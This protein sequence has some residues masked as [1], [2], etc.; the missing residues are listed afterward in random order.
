MMNDNSG[1]EKD[2]N[3][4]LE[5]FETARETNKTIYLDSEDYCDI[6][7]FYLRENAIENGHDAINRGLKIHPNHTVLLSIQVS[8]YIAEDKLTEAR[9]VLESIPNRNNIYAR[10]AEGELLTH[11]GEKEVA[12]TILKSIKMEDL[13]GDFSLMV[14]ITFLFSQ[15]EMPDEALEWIHANILNNP[16]EDEVFKAALAE[17]YSI[18]G[19]ND[20][21]S[22]LYNE[23]LDTD[24][25]NSEYWIGLANCLFG[26]AEYN[27]VIEAIDFALVSDE[28]NGEA[29][30]LKANAF[31]Q[32]NNYEKALEEYQLSDL[33]PLYLHLFM[34]YC[35]IGLQQDEVAYYQFSEALEHTEID[36]TISIHIIQNIVRCARAIGKD[37]EAYDYCILL[38]NNFPDLADGF[39]L[40][41]TLYMEDGDLTEALS[42]WQ[43]AL[44]ISNS[45][46]V[47]YQMAT[48]TFNA[49]YYSNAEP[50]FEKVELL[51]PDYEE[52]NRYLTTLYLYLGDVE[53]F[54]IYRNKL[55]LSLETEVHPDIDTLLQI[56]KIDYSD[57]TPEA[58]LLLLRL[59]NDK[60]YD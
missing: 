40:H 50:F 46:F 57:L 11:E 2:F 14:T 55:F 32:L 48:S 3:R 10:V 29:H 51:E 22:L 43:K 52:T 45:A 21:A 41:G 12:R 27:K 19:M 44:K 15:L 33:S 58:N 26:Q 18:L 42:Y 28:S 34:G 23:L 24:P 49:G 1:P 35:Y 13:K 56:L 47:W 54:L 60:L 16:S 17:G 38:E 6:A 39:L 20:E 53:K 5:Q 9:E 36:D 30:S 7:N 59:E 8:L 31:L 37:K 25:Y 4:L